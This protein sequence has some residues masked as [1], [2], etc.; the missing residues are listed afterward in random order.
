MKPEELLVQLVAGP[1]DGNGFTDTPD[2]V[3]MARTEEKHGGQARVRLAPTA[4]PG[5]GRMCTAC[6]C[7]P[8]H[9][10]WPRRWRRGWSCGDKPDLFGTGLWKGYL[11][12]PLSSVGAL[13]APGVVYATGAR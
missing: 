6:E 13:N 3:D 8:S 11:G 2:V 4:R 5:A 9:R 10:G 7:F 1:G 12:T